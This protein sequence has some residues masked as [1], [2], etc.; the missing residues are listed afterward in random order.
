[1]SESLKPS[2]EPGVQAKQRMRWFVGLMKKLTVA[3]AQEMSEARMALYADALL[4]LTDARIEFAFEAALVRSKYL[5][6]IAE[7]FEFAHEFKP[8]PSLPEFLQDNLG[9]NPLT[10]VT[11]KFKRG[12]SV[13]ETDMA[14]WRERGR[15]RHEQI[16]VDI[17]RSDDR[18]DLAG[19]DPAIERKINSLRV[20]M[21]HPLA[22]DPEEFEIELS[23]ARRPRPRREA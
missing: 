5:P 19:G 11:E 18:R 9:R 17:A 8:E 21:N 3:Y 10:E 22:V 12:G 23:T 15:I 20:S 1:M 6:T 14:Q 7:L 13:T 2:E 4:H 16:L